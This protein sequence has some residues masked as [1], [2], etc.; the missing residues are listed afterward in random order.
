MLATI[1]AL[2]RWSKSSEITSLYFDADLCRHGNF[3]PLFAYHLSSLLLKS[4]KI[5]RCMGKKCLPFF[6]ILLIKLQKPGVTFF[7]LGQAKSFELSEEVIDGQLVSINAL[8]VV[9][10]FSGDFTMF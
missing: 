3:L 10:L 7:L 1:S 4:G 6:I 8:E 9:N 5:F 2:V